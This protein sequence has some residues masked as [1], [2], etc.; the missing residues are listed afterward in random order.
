MDSGHEHLQYMDMDMEHGTW[1]MEQGHGDGHE[2]GHTHMT[3][4]NRVTLLLCD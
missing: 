3:N 4:C 2:N 1:N